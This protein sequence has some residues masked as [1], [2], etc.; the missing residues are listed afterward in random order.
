M[1]AEPVCRNLQEMPMLKFDRQPS[2]VAPGRH[3]IAIALSPLRVA[4]LLFVCLTLTAE[5]SG[6]FRAGAAKVEITPPP[7]V[8]LDGPISKNGPVSSIH[9]P[10][11]ARA[12]VLDDGVLD[13]GNRKLAIVVVD[14]CMTGAE[15][16]D[17]AKQQIDR[18]IGIPTDRILM[19]AT[20]THAAPRTVHIGREAIDDRYHHQLADW[21]AE[22]VIA[23]DKNLAPAAIGYASFEKPELLACRRYICDPG[24]VR[25][26][27]FGH[28]GERIKSVAGKSTAVI[29][30]AGPTDP[31]FSV[32]SVRHADGTPLCLLGNFSVHYCGGYQ[33]G[34]VSADYFGYFAA[35]VE[36]KLGSDSTH[37]PIVGIMS[38][39]TSGDTGSFKS[40]DGRK[41]EA[42]EGMQFYGRMLAEEAIRAV[43]GA[44]HRTDV[45]LDMRQRTLELAVRRPDAERIAW[46]KQV[47]Q[48]PKAAHPHSWTKIYAQEAL[49]LSEYPPTWLVKL[50]AIR[51]GEIAIAAAPSEVFAETGL[52]IKRQSPIR[53]TFNM[54]LANGYSGYLPTREQH[55]MGGYE[56]WPARSSLLEVAAEE[57][58][59]REL[60][61]LLADVE[62]QP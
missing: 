43:E 29:G 9:D 60:L 18:A 2:S 27:P 54:E 10:L 24:S 33:R 25:A 4:I 57:Q 38:N 62:D 17:A 59:R 37:P 41:F 45:T 16:F 1:V 48:Q 15:I 32:L 20:H 42:F 49:H 56:S 7:G 50:Q 23:A 36:S 52:A 58:I 39:G 21:I 22:A 46:A 13:D 19:A 34:A 53:S 11:H 44:D 47:M 30:P 26:N 3:R 40:T 35:A 8:S 31:Q 14:Q 61:S 12:L 51:I 5:S 6:Q 28:A 55:E